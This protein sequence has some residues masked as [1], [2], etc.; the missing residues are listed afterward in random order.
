MHLDYDW[1]MKGVLHYELLKPGKTVNAERYCDQLNN[2]AEKN[3]RKKTIYWSRKSE[4]HLHDNA[5]LHVARTTQ[6]TIF[7]LGWKV[8]PH[9]AYLLDLV[10]SDYHLFW[11]MQHALAR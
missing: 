6:Q 3:R 1:N 10:P 11:S 7:N 5:R 2:L 4:S 9:A 8:L